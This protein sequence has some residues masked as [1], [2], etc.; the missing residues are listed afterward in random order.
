MLFQIFRISLAGMEWYHIPACRDNILS[1]EST[2]VCEYEWGVY[3]PF[4][5]GGSGS[6]CA[7]VL[8]HELQYMGSVV[9]VYKRKMIGGAACHLQQLIRKE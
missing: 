9:G 3:C 8:M 4:R 2:Y 7:D 5:A 6:R 1:M